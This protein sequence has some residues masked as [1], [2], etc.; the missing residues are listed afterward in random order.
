MPQLG[1]CLPYDWTHR[2]NGMVS[3]CFETKR[4]QVHCEDFSE[5]EWGKKQVEELQIQGIDMMGRKFFYSY[6]RGIA[7][8]LCQEHFGK[9]QSLLKNVKEVCITGGMEWASDDAVIN[10]K[11]KALETSKGLVTR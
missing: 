5:P 3:R 4:V 2:V 9:I 7:G 8:P 11:W 1:F 10:S 6:E